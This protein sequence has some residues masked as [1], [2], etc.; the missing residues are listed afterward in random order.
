[1]MVTQLYI[2][3]KISHSKFIITM[4]FACIF[5]VFFISIQ[6]PYTPPTITTL[7][8][9]STR[10]FSFLLHPSNPNSLPY[11]CSCHSTLH[12][13]LSLFCLLIQFVHQIPHMSGIIW[14]LSFS[15]WLIALSLIFSRSIHAVAKGK[16]FFFFKAKL[17]S[18]V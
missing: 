2:L 12:L 8:S 10:P 15:G 6:S 16:I 5:I 4:L 7:L 1:M 17:Y 14:Y 11:S 18:I 9:V 13:R 3:R